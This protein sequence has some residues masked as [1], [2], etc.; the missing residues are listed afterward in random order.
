MSKL[1]L[2]E[3]IDKGKLPQFIKEN[4]G[5]AGNKKQFNQAIDSMTNKSKPARQTSKKGS[6]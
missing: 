6:S 2:K 5:L 3:A 4:Q 1:T